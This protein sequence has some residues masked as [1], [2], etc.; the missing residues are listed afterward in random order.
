VNVGSLTYI[1]HCQET[2]S[3]YSKW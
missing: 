1:F 2:M 3:S